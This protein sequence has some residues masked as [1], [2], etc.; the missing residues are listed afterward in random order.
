MKHT[1]REED[2]MKTHMLAPFLHP[3]AIPLLKGLTDPRGR[4][5]RYGFFVC[6]TFASVFTHGL[7][8]L[9]GSPAPQTPLGSLM[10][11]GLVWIHGVPCVRRLHDLGKSGWWFLPVSAL[12]LAIGAAL[13]FGLTPLMMRGGIDIVTAPT[14]SLGAYSLMGI[15]ALPLVI[16][17]FWLSAQK[18]QDKENHYG[19]CPTHYG[20]SEAK[21]RCVKH[22]VQTFS[23]SS[24]PLV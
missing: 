20:V 7:L 8:K 21:Y 22:E 4:T 23:S 3:C 9:L 6:L 11:I 14:P 12:L 5:N 18:G 17:A 19:S 2:N 16:G 10:L 13:I 15:G 24:S 1:M